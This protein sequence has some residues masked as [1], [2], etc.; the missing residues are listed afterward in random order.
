VLTEQRILI[1]PRRE[2]LIEAYQ[3]ASKTLVLSG[4][5]V[6][7]LEV[8][9]SPYTDEPAVTVQRAASA[10]PIA[11]GR[12]V[13]AGELVNVQARGTFTVGSW[14][15]DTLNP[16]GYPSDDARSYNLAP[17]QTAPHAC[18]IALIGGGRTIDGVA[19]GVGKEFVAAHAGTLRLGLNDKDLSNNEG[20]VAY[21]VARRA[22]TA[23]E[24]R[25]GGRRR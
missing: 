22:P 20:Q 4:G 25:A 9:L 10:E 11:L 14:F 7:R 16:A 15:D 13:M 2:K 24:W 21:T 6:R 17:F 18:A 1:E 12:P 5:A 19:V 23:E 3:S 8:V